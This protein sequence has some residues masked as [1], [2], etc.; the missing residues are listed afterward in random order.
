MFTKEAVNRIT[1]AK[2]SLLQT[3]NMKMSQLQDPKLTAM[4]RQDC[5]IS[6]GCISSIIVGKPI[7]DIDVYAKKSTSIK[8][9]SDYLLASPDIIKKGDDSYELGDTK[10]L[11]TNNAITLVND[12]QF[13]RIMS[14]EQGARQHFDFVHCMPWYDI[15]ANKLYISQM[16]YDS[17]MQLLLIPNLS[18]E[19]IKRR[20]VDKYIQK[21]WGIDAEV[22]ETIYNNSIA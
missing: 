12:V 8:L 1:Q 22:K 14:D 17:I 11:V 13:I 19:K 20:R 3:Y 21:G 18:L 9:I 5:I 7:N 6:G 2:N 16:Q 15:H 10:P 4:F